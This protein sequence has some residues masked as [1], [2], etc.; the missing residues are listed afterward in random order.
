MGI[1]IYQ[2]NLIV[3]KENAYEKQMVG[4]AAANPRFTKR[5]PRGNETWSWLAFALINLGV[6]WVIAETVFAIQGL[7]LVGRIAECGG[8]LAFGLAA[9]GRVRPIN[10]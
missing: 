8:V 5:A 2:I 9:W 6:G 1:P 10:P 7:A 3:E 4:Q